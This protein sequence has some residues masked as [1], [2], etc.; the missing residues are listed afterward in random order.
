MKTFAEYQIIGRIGRVIPAGSALKVSVAADYGRR[1]DK[2]AWEE[3]PFW[4]TVTVFNEN[5]IR[6]ARDNLGTGDLIHVRGT[7]R[8]VSYDKDGE[9][10]YGVSLSAD[11]LDLL[12]KKQGAA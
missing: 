5:M 8:E 1:N 11:Q 12:A 4:N 2:G 6:W 10:R 3:K 7:I 9:T